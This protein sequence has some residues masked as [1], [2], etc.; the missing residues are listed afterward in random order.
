V[1]SQDQAWAAFG[2]LGHMTFPIS[3]EIQYSHLIMSHERV[4]ALNAA[5]M[6]F[7]TG[8]SRFATSV[9]AEKISNLNARENQLHAMGRMVDEC[10]RVLQDESRDLN[11]VGYLLDEAW[12]LK[13]QLAAGVSNPT[14]DEIYAA[15][16]E[17]GALGGKLLG[18]GGGGFMLFYA[19]PHAQA[20]IR[21]RLKRL[22]EVTFTI[23]SPG[24]SVVLYEPDRLG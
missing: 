15:G 14:I 6:L 24:S 1:G 5:L 13:R 8:L 19:P 20:R 12:Q 17:A 7:F 22:I 10:V 11:E 21:E 16:I 9:A 23:N 2:G 3:G 4:Q 18:A